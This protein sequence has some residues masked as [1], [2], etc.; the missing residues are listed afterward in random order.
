MS[1]KIRNSIIL[2]SFALL[3]TLGGSAFWMWW[4]PRQLNKIKA[5]LDNV[6]KQLDE[7]PVLIQEVAALTSQ[8]QDRKRKYDSRSKEIPPYDISSQTYAYMS[9][10]LDEAGFMKFNMKFETS[11]DFGQYGYNTYRLVEGE[12]QFENLYKFIYYLENGRRLYKIK[13][14]SFSH[15]EALDPD[16]KETKT[17]ILFNVEFHAYFTTIVELGTSLAAKALPVPPSPFNPFKPLVLGTLTTEAPE[18]ELNSNNLE[19]KAII[20][21][22]AFALYDAELIV[23]QM[24]DKVWRGYVSK[25]DPTSASVE[26]TLDEGGVIRKS[27]KYVLFDKKLRTR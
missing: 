24:G 19:L 12:G 20:P 23:L 22:K 10:G 7:L 26:F 4:Q 3:V 2:G 21:G 17:S 15:Y 8:F 6:N 13:S 14:V 1:F 11:E 25:I 18:G 16:T 27:V 9:Q 5:E